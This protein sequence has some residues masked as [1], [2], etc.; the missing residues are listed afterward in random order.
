MPDALLDD[1]QSSLDLVP[2]LL[3]RPWPL[4]AVGDLV[5]KNPPLAVRLPDE[6][7]HQ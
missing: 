2:V 7:F 6:H 1:L 4:R 5:E 3:D